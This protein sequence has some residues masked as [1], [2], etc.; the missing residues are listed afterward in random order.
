MSCTIV[1]V[2]V[3]VVCSVFNG[4]ENRSD[5]D[6]CRSWEEKSKK[7]ATV[8]SHMN[9]NLKNTHGR[10]HARSEYLFF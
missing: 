1:V 10:A 6:S 4:I 8:K 5:E 9:A 2:V 3:V 7:R